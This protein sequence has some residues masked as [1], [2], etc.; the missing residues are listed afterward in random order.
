MP[1]AG[2]PE[3]SHGL[4]DCCFS[5][6]AKVFAEVFFGA[7]ASQQM[8]AAPIAHTVEDSTSNP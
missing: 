8:L 1:D 2:E 7:M 3:E 5:D 4:A 6:F